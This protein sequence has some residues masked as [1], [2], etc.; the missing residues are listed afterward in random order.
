MKTPIF[1]GTATALVTP[2]TENGIDTAALKK[3]VDW[4]IDQGVSALIACG[5]TGEP[6]TM[7][8]AEWEETVSTVIKAA[9][10]R[11]PVVAGT[12]S[13]N[14]AHVIKLAKLAK[15]LGADAQLVVTPYYNKTTQQG[16]IAHYTAIADEGSLPVVVYNVPARTGLNMLP[17][18]LGKLSHHPNIV[19]M[20]EASG[21]L[22]QIT[23]MMR[24]CEDRIAFYSGSDEVVVPLMALGGQGVISV[25]S[26][27]APDLT[28]QMTGAML[29]GD[30]QKAAGL[31]IRLMPLIRA[32]FVETNPIPAK[33]G[34]SLLGFCENRVRLPLIPMTEKNYSVLKAEMEKL[35]LIQ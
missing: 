19:A 12:G 10:G 25:M 32:L 18:T 28:V 29:D 31:Q 8:E 34:V 3:L 11:V 35:G 1:T 15:K 22:I 33:A 30:F 17:D 7:D 27:V 20:K 2:F 6:S 16:L 4:Q 9:K 24:L 23:E 13:N 21:D 26:N 5:T 14:T